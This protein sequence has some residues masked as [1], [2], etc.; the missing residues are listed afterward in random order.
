[1]VQLVQTLP[2]I[3]CHRSFNMSA[4]WWQNFANNFAADLAPLLSLFGEQTTKQFLSEILTFVDIVVF[5]IAPIGVLTAVVSAIR[6][7][8]DPSLRAFVGRA[9][10]GGAYAEAELCSST[11][12]DV[13]ELYTSGGIAR[14]FGRPK[15]LEV[16]HDPSKGQDPT[17]AGIHTFKDY[18]SLGEE[19]SEWT[20]KRTAKENSF[21]EHPNLSLNI[22]IKKRDRLWFYFAAALGLVLQGGVPIFA[23][24]VTYVYPDTFKRDDT[25]IA[26]P[27]FPFTFTGTILLCTGV[28]L[29]ATVVERCTKERVFHRKKKACRLHW[30]QPGGQ[31]IGDQVFDS[32]AFSETSENLLEQYTISWKPD[33]RT[34]KHGSEQATKTTLLV[35]AAI[36][37]TCVGFIS[38]FLGIRTL[39][40]SVSVAQ[41]VVMLIMSTVRALLRTQRLKKSDNQMGDSYT[42]YQGHEL[43]WLAIKLACQE[44]NHGDG[45]NKKNHSDGA[46]KKNHGDGRWTWQIIRPFEGFSYEA[47]DLSRNISKVP[48][49]HRPSTD[50]VSGPDIQQAFL[51][52]ARLAR[53]TGAQC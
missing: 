42:L 29:C 34:L 2:H 5:S 22:G 10:E 16:V 36:T 52:R 45:A 18:S 11:S 35:W 48:S 24:L 39:H 43:D 1:M 53:L 28:G 40:S 14:V 9:Q 46:D 30:I 31:V 49:I 6:V 4:D 7:S 3:P 20:E 41:F 37:T 27:A 25:Q 19:N 23:A 15:I 38:Q 33:E 12:R 47:V 8:G 13:C 26:V 50:V 32:F 44:K 21:A 17:T 51:Q